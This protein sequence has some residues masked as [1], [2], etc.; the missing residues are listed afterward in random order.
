M[1]SFRK[2]IAILAALALFCVQIPIGMLIGAS[3]E[4]VWSDNLVADSQKNMTLTSYDATYLDGITL[5]GEST[6]EFS[7][8]MKIPTGSLATTNL[9]VILS[10]N[11]D[12]TKGIYSDYW[13]SINQ[14]RTGA[15]I[16]GNGW[17]NSEYDTLVNGTITFAEDTTYNVKYVIE[18]DKVTYYINDTLVKVT[19]GTSGGYAEADSTAIPTFADAKIGFVAQNAAPNIELSNISVK[20][21]ASEPSE[22]EGPA[23]SDNLVAD[24]QQ[25]IVVN[26][27][28]KHLL[29]GITLDGESTYEFAFD[30]KIP[31]GSLAATNLCVIL[32]ENADATKGIYSDYWFSMNQI[33]TGSAV[34]GNGWPNSEYDTL[35][36]GTIAFAEDTT[37]NVKYIIEK[38]KV[39]YYINDT[40]V[41][42]TLGTAG[43]YAEADSTAIPTFADAK[44]GFVG[45]NATPNIEITNISV[46][47]Q[48]S[49]EPEVPAGP[50]WGTENLVAGQGDIHLNGAYAPVYL[51][52]I[53][54][55]NT[56]YKLDYTVTFNSN[57]A[58]HWNYVSN[59]LRQ[60]ENDLISFGAWNDAGDG[61]GQLRFAEND[62]S[63]NVWTAVEGVGTIP[64]GVGFPMS[65][66]IMPE[67]LELYINGQIQT[68]NLASG[69]TATQ[70]PV[71]K[72]IENGKIGFI[73]QG[74]HPD[75]TISNIALYKDTNSVVEPEPEDPVEPED[76]TETWTEVATQ[77][78]VTVDE[79]N[80][81]IYQWV[82]DE[83]D[84]NATYKIEYTLTYT[85]HV[86]DSNLASTA[87]RGVPAAEAWEA[88]GLFMAHDNFQKIRIGD[89]YDTYGT[90]YGAGGTADAT[91][92]PVKY[93][94]ISAPESVT[95]YVDGVLMKQYD[96]VNGVDG[97]DSVPVPKV[98]GAK[99]GFR[100]FGA[101]PRFTV[102]DISVKVKS[103]A[104]GS[105]P[106][107][108]AGPVWGTENLVAGQ[109]DIHLNGAYTAVY[110]DEILDK[111]TGY[112]LDYT[113]TFNTVV[114]GN[115]NNLS[116]MLRQNDTD[117]ISFGW[118]ADAS[119][120]GDGQ[121]RFAEN[122]ISNGN[123]TAVQSATPVAGQAYD[124]SI[125]IMPD[126]VELY[127][128]GQIVTMYLTAGGTAT[129]IPVSKRIA[130]GKIGFIDQ[131]SHP[132]MT[133]SNIALYADTNGADAP[134]IDQE[135]VDAVIAQ[136]GAIG[137]VTKDSADVIKAARAA[138]DALNDEEK[139][140]VTNFETLTAAESALKLLTASQDMKLYALDGTYAMGYNHWGAMVSVSNATGG[141]MRYTW[142]GAGTN[143]RRGINR[144]VALDGL[145]LVASGLNLTSDNKA[146]AFYIADFDQAESY[147]QYEPLAE[148]FPLAIILNM[149]AGT[150]EI[151]SDPLEKATEV[152]ATNDALKYDSMK[153]IEWSLSIDA[154]DDG[155]YTV[156]INGVSG[157]ISKELMD[158]VQRLTQ[159]DYAFITVSP[160]SDVNNSGAV[161]G[162]VDFLSLHGGGNACADSL[163][164]EEM[165]AVT[166]LIADIAAIG[167][168]TKDSKDAIEACEA[169]YAA[170]NDAQKGCVTNY[171]ALAA[172]RYRYNLLTQTVDIPCINYYQIT[173]ADTGGTN[174]W[175]AN[176]MLTHENAT[177][178]GVTF[179]WQNGGTNVRRFIDR[180]VTLD[181]FHMVLSN[182]DM[183]KGLS[184]F[185]FFFAD[186]Y[187]TAADWTS[188]YSEY[189]QNEPT[190]AVLIFDA[191]SGTVSVQ[192]GNESV[193]VLRDDRLTYEFLEGATWDIKIEKR[194]DGDYTFIANGAEGIIPA[195]FLDKATRLTDR[196]NEMY[197]TVSAWGN[198][199]NYSYDLVA[200]HGGNVVCAEDLTDEME[201]DLNEVIEAIYAIYDGNWQIQPSAEA[202]YNKAWDLYDALPEEVQSLVANYADLVVATDVLEVVLAIDSL[203]TI[204]LESGDEIEDVRK[205]YKNLAILFEEETGGSYQRVN[206]DTDRRLLVG[207][208]ATLDK[209]IRTY[210]NLYKDAALNGTAT[211][212]DGSG[213]N[214]GSG[215]G[216]G[217]PSIPVTGDA[218][219]YVAILVLVASLVAA[220]AVC[221]KTVRKES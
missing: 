187:D 63:N 10:E 190:C 76:P 72:L 34:D 207:N 52:E 6:Y 88:T 107:V 8:D 122:D 194:A 83:L 154:N 185:A 18:K 220:A 58:G 3:A 78:S 212:G 128:D 23:W 164:A 104:G 132:N 192:I 44:V 133:I 109:E 13:F 32:S 152:I 19:L 160:W 143:F 5:D 181:G 105:D 149:N 67:Y 123:Q 61:T 131:G 204:T 198:G 27:Y 151:G 221:K 188:L 62:I 209:A 108:P 134:A 92:T 137:T 129:Q 157:V 84:Q 7:F 99:V 147:S 144:G 117:L 97:K 196:D 168:V 21:A 96:F 85:D 138:Y 182:L 183:S 184:S 41:K 195:S 193:V 119:G 69:G 215:D 124:I 208:Y 191:V 115:W 64:A 136:I 17:P 66:V 35:V 91:A 101:N 16:D 158:K 112:K 70:I 203:G 173:N 145:H 81:Y 177:E 163:N 162:S 146:I 161:S 42:V 102:T 103:D 24:A 139:A 36:N 60:N 167:T 216:T 189:L 20:Q 12:A 155:S 113:L 29:N 39:T 127:V 218:F 37:Y 22:P 116:N 199:V 26:S 57:V 30:M 118:W 169:A 126:Y 217:T 80:P 73:D 121:L 4:E 2:P 142:D 95:V 175:Q 114:P 54:D 68:M 174:H 210:Y 98:A 31:T 125:V 11:A 211:G 200:I 156:T 51:D 14:I 1:K 153:D 130:N 180:K 219:P 86:N 120:N 38:D 25:T 55:K 140:L 59:M 46:K 89:T 40:L 79:T 45:Q 94:I 49:S 87:F 33:R 110:L 205:M 9:C 111:H 171:K 148:Y 206:I 90:L 50:V 141:G 82:T 71:S 106:E 179:K 201:K 74:S 65:I 166:D 100:G 93:T 159:L 165:K 213:N 28:D 75:I 150:I 170:L 178:G 48:A 43:G 176:D 53:L 77:T 197:V 15:A 56:G 172:A 47:K 214:G 186:L 202:A 135:A